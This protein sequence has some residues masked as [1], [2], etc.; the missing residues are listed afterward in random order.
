MTPANIAI[1]V[2]IGLI[3]LLAILFWF[4]A[5]HFASMKPKEKEMFE[6]ELAERALNEKELRDKIIKVIKNE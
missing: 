5:K 1:T 2:L 3:V 6:D 4:L